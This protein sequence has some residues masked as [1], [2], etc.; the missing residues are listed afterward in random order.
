M[1]E[2][3]VSPSKRY[4]GAQKRLA[5]NGGM[6]AKPSLGKWASQAKSGSLSPAHEDNPIDAAD[7]SVGLM[8]DGEARRDQ[9]MNVNLAHSRTVSNTLPSQEIIEHS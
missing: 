3:G 5:N 9:G 2:P 1:T 7:A 6:Q 8:P 4:I